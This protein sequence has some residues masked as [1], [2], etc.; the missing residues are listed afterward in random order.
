ML[1]LVERAAADPCE[2]GRWWTVCLLVDFLAPMPMHVP[3]MDGRWDALQRMRTA[4]HSCLSCCGALV[5]RLRPHLHGAGGRG[6]HPGRTSTRGP[7]EAGPP[8]SVIEGGPASLRTTNAIP[9]IMS[10]V[11][12]ILRKEM[13]LLSPT[14]HDDSSPRGTAAWP[15]TERRELDRSAQEQDGEPSRPSL[16]GKPRARRSSWAT[17]VVSSADS[18][19]RICHN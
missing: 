1:V 12:S 18:Y 19:M 2:G 11:P 15:A 10:L 6:L 3:S 5:L 14:M 13:R 17:D 8:P 7:E 9:S 16:R 4:C